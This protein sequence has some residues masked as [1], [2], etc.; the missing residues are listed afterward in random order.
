MAIFANGCLLT[1]AE[2][3]KY[4]PE[5]FVGSDLASDGAEGG[6]GVANVLGEEVCR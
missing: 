6:D 3:P 2:L 4:F 5:D 1:H